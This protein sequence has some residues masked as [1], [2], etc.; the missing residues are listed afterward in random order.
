[1]T[2]VFDY[3]ES[4]GSRAKILMIRARAVRIE[5]LQCSHGEQASYVCTYMCCL[6]KRNSETKCGPGIENSFYGFGAGTQVFVV[7]D[8]S[9]KYDQRILARLTIRGPAE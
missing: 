1:M 8:V 2:D 3:A 5:L 4:F 7:L 9:S 6:L